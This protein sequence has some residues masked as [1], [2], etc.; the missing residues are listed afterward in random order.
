MYSRGVLERLLTKELAG[1]ENYNVD[2]YKRVGYNL[3]FNTLS[4]TE[5]LKQ[6]RLR[7]LDLQKKANEIIP[8][9]GSYTLTK[10]LNSQ[11]Q[12]NHSE[13]D[14]SINT[15]IDGLAKEMP[16]KILASTK[17]YST[18]NINFLY[19][20]D[21]EASK[22]QGAAF[23][24]SIEGI[25]KHIDLIKGRLYSNKKTDA[26]EYEIIVSKESA[27]N[28]KFVLNGVYQIWG[29][30]MSLT[31]NIRVKVVGIY[32]LKADGDP[33]AYGAAWE[34][35]ISMVIDPEVFSKE[36][37]EK[38]KTPLSRIH[39][40]YA[41]DYKSIT[42]K[43][44][45]KILSLVKKHN[46]ELTRYKDITLKLSSNEVLESYLS[47]GKDLNSTMWVFQ[48]PVFIIIL[49]YLSMLSSLMI[50][51]EKDEIT[52]LKSRGASRGYIFNLYLVESLLIC[53]VAVV[54]GPILGIFICKILGSSNGFMQFVDRA[55]LIVSLTLEEYAYSIAAC[56]F[57]LVVML[58]PVINVSKT[59]IVER[60]RGKFRVSSS[61]KPLW[62]RFYL[63]V[64]LL[65]ISIYGYFG[66]KRRQGIFKVS[67]V[68]PGDIP[69]D[70][71]LYV[72]VI[73]LI[74]GLGLL[75]LRIYPYIIKIILKVGNRLWSPSTYAALVNICRTKGKE[76]L[77]MIFLIL[78]VS[79]GIFNI[80]AADTIN[81][82]LENTSRYLSGTDI[83]LTQNWIREPEVSPGY[84][85]PNFEQFKNIQGIEAATKVFIKENVTLDHFK[86]KGSKASYL[87]GIETDSFGK[88]AWFNPSLMNT[89]WYNYLNLLAQDPKAVLISKSL[90]KKFSL[91]EGDTI[92]YRWGE[93]YVEGNVFGVVDYWPSYNSKDIKFEGLIVANLGYLQ[94]ALAIQPYEVWLK[95][96][97]G[98]NS[99]DTYKAIIDLNLNLTSAKD[100][101]TIIATQKNDPSVLGTNG[102]LTLSFLSSMLITALGF[103]IFW[104]LSIRNRILQLGILRSMGLSMRKIIYMLIIEQILVSGPALLVGILIGSS[105]SNFT[106]PLIDISTNPKGLV[107]PNLPASFSNSYIQIFIVFAV[108]LITCALI[109]IRFVSKLK[110]S[111]A[112][113]L[114]ED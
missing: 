36:L 70:P 90:Q 2:Y 4:S 27:E 10:E 18:E 48:F 77:L 83:R 99:S 79:T 113:K 65:I 93:L 58:Y 67:S 35:A 12:D 29:G 87:M 3:N 106:L 22:N 71:I 57:F 78:T 62:M 114:G 82:R 16:I 17:I 26:G 15:H 55:P 98:S 52:V 84:Q 89:H 34:N 94:K 105:T 102:A 20:T 44:T 85:E 72:I 68:K 45:V 14:S 47:K 101:N 33:Y 76:Q 69:V 88:T 97:S 13:I 30:N 53:A 63:D 5:K 73:S 8:Y 40:F 19:I 32:S 59:S 60:K 64:V 11:E 54:V 109:L 43:N 50:E 31:N 104:M 6:E 112:V 91:A 49:F 1:F 100:V 96:K 51:R 95:Q 103:L 111:Q 24:K 80:K 25:D 75:F 39:W 28:N 86:Q 21:T 61:T 74:L 107:I 37:L 46:A 81:S 92:R 41:L 66:Y 23:I 110:M 9:A 7:T 38:E 42:I 56:V 108:M